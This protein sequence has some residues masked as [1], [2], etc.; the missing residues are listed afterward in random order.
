[1]NKLRFDRM[2]R[3]AKE[4]DPEA[5]EQLKQYI[6]SHASLANKHLKELE[7]T[8]N[9]YFAYSRAMKYLNVDEGVSRFAGVTAGVPIDV[10][11]ARAE[12][13]NTFLSSKTH[14][15][16]GNEQAWAKQEKGLRALIE[17]GYASVTTDRMSISQ[18][19]AAIAR[20]QK[21]LGN[22]GVRITQGERY[23]IIESLSQAIDDFKAN[24]KT[25]DDSELDLILSRYLTGERIYNNL[26]AGVIGQDMVEKND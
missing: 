3:Q 6:R 8:G 21:N 4:G 26:V 23:N 25:I 1:M 18:I 2:I 22:D 17:A 24:G 7:Q 14:T 11:T 19:S 15:V 10:L 5:E 13:I 9:T 20:A 16:L 12:E